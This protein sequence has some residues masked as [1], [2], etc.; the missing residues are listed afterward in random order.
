[1]VID[2]YCDNDTYD[3]LI[4]KWHYSITYFAVSCEEFAS[5]SHYEVL[6]MGLAMLIVEG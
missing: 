2:D 1:M 6:Y 5:H 3:M 4:H